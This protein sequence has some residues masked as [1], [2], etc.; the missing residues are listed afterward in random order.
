MTFSEQYEDE[1]VIWTPAVSNHPLLHHS[2]SSNL[3]TGKPYAQS[4][5]QGRESLRQVREVPRS[6]P[7]LRGQRR[8]KRSHS[9]SQV[10]YL[11][12]ASSTF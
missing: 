4:Q 11:L 1:S 9:V 2:H 12:T 6:L 7:H 3:N 8:W 10:L 5:G